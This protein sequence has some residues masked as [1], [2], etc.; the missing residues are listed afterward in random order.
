ME[1]YTNQIKE[2]TDYENQYR[3]A[4]A[5]RKHQ[6]FRLGRKWRTEEQTRVVDPLCSIWCLSQVRHYA[7]IPFELLRNH[8]NKLIWLPYR[9]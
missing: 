4:V 2:W 3:I 5:S 7:H 1:I 8:L 6:L 9:P